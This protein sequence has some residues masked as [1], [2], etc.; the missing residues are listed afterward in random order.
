MNR[1]DEI[2]LVKR[3]RL[4]DTEMET[5]RE[6]WNNEYP[7]SLYNTKEEFNLLAELI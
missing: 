1:A 5:I 3:A 7:E 4:S 6:I 2:Q